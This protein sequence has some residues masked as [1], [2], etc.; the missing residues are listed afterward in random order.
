VL[1]AQFHA[2]LSVVLLYQPVWLGCEAEAG[3]HVG[4]VVSV[5]LVISENTAELVCTVAPPSVAVTA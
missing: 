2:M 5:R 4:A 1:S 3:A